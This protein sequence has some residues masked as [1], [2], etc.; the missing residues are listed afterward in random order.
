[1]IRGISDICLQDALIHVHTF[2]SKYRAAHTPQRTAR[3]T[4]QGF[5]VETPRPPIGAFPIVG[6]R[7]RTCTPPEDRESD[8]E[9]NSFEGS[10]AV[11]ASWM[12]PH[13]QL[14]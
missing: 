10:E 11:G 7:V 14:R 9:R 13:A 2:T 5:Q 6:F 8:R 1:M 4:R 12:T 3:G